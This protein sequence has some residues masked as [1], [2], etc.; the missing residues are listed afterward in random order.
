MVQNYGNSNWTPDVGECVWVDWGP[1][2]YSSEAPMT[3]AI[4]VG[5][6]QPPF[7]VQPRL[8]CGGV[9][10]GSCGDNNKANSNHTGGVQVGMGDGSVRMVSTGVSTATWWYALTPAGG[11]VLG[12]DW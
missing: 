12:N 3:G 8:G 9:P 2:S 6:T 7:W 10:F 1:V 11:E 4:G 5:M